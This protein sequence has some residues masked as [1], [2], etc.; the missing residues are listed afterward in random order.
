[1]VYLSRDLIKH[2][3]FQEIE[4]LNWGK[5]SILQQDENI[6]FYD[7]Q[8]ISLITSDWIPFSCG[9]SAKDEIVYHEYFHLEIIKYIKVLNKDDGYSREYIYKLCPYD[10]RD[11]IK[12]SNNSIRISAK[13]LKKEKTNWDI[14]DEGRPSC[15]I[16]FNPYVFGDFYIDILSNSEIQMCDQYL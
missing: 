14:V 8:K 16:L 1:M 13:Y 15:A 3:S 7:G 4:L 9:L 11:R 2:F 6:F 12:L 10:F 5:V